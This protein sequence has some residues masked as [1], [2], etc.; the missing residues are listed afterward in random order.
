MAK[1]HV[2]RE[3]NRRRPLNVAIWWL[4]I[5]RNPPLCLALH[6]GSVNLPRLIVKLSKPTTVH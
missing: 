4:A 3:R 6:G 5:Q 1:R 2:Y